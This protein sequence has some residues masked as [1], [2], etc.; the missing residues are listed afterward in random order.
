MESI[1]RAHFSRYPE[2]QLQDL[3]KLLHQ[4]AFGS[5]HAI[6]SAERARAWLNREIAEMGAGAEPLAIEPILPNAEIVRVH[7]RPF[8]AQG[9][10]LENLLAAFLRTADA[11]TGSDE[12]FEHYWGIARELAHFSIDETDTFI[13]PLREKKFPAIHHSTLYRETYRPAYRVVLR[14]LLES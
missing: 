5:E 1:L 12:K 14:K 6:P 2:M 8:L 11:F 10:D 13:T 7:L 3:Y 9:G 4:A